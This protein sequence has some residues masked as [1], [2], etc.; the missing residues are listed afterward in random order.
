MNPANPAGAMQATAGGNAGY[1]GPKPP[2]GSVHNYVFQV[3][4]LDTTLT[5]LDT[6]A[7]APMLIMAMMGHVVAAGSFNAPYTGK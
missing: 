5:G 3:F 6:M 7:N 4:A 1:R 2:A